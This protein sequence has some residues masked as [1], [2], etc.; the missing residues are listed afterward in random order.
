[1][2]TTAATRATGLWFSRVVIRRPFDALLTTTDS[3][4]R[5]TLGAVFG[6]A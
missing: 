6:A 3:V 4:G 2:R 1:V 5:A